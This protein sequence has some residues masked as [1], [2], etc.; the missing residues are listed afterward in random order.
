MD[1][2]KVEEEVEEVEQ[3]KESQGKA[4]RDEG[5]GRKRR[6]GEAGRICAHVIYF[7]LPLE[8]ASGLPA[9]AF[10]ASFFAVS[11]ARLVPLLFALFSC[12]IFFFC[13]GVSL[14]FF[15]GPAALFLLFPMF[16]N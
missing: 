14:S 3:Q 16:V 8:W 4:E 7:F 6:G 9:L 10:L 11:S 5:G 1:V 12:L 13:A 2:E 15:S